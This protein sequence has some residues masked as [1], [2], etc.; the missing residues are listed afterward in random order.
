MDFFYQNT[1]GQDHVLSQ[2]YRHIFK[3]GNSGV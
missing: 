2:I 3:I 1:K